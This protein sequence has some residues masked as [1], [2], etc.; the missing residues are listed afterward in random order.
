LWDTW[1][2]FKSQ[3]Y[4]WGD[5]ETMFTAWDE[6]ALTELIDSHA[7]VNSALKKAGKRKLHAA[8][9]V[10]DDLADSP[11]FHNNHNLISRL[12][13]MGRHVGVQCICL[14]QKWKALSTV[15]RSQTCFIVLFR[16][17]N[18]KEKDAILEELS[19]LYP[20]KTLEELYNEATDGR[21]SF[22]YLNMLAD[23]R[24]DVFYKRFDFRMLPT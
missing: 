7:A 13:L 12:F 11:Q 3:H 21:H 15:V 16:M 19:G 5:E 14:S 2:A 24:Q 1:R 4:D 18:K 6:D 20:M 8:C 23:R 22:M 9:L 17:R 10:I